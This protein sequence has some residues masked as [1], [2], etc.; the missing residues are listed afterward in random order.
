MNTPD[1][2][3]VG[4]ID[5]RRVLSA[6]EMVENLMAEVEEDLARR[7]ILNPPRPEAHPEPLANLDSTKLT[8]ADLASLYTQYV[9]YSSYIGDELAK[10]EGLEEAAKR[11]LRDT[12]MQLKHAQFLRNVKG[13]QATAAAMQDP[14][15]QEL[16]IEHSKL[17]FMRAIMK[18]RYDGYVAQAAALSRTVELRKLDFEQTRRDTSIG[19]GKRP[20]FPSGF[21]SPSSKSSSYRKNG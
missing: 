1:F 2:T 5:E 19:H 4:L 14:M 13:P 10:I 7:G 8:N 15:Y 18:R 9:A 16:D 17:F 12:L 6:R 3:R 21:G 11:L 20:N